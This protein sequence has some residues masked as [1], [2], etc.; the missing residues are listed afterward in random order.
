MRI[1][2]T[3]RHVEPSQAL[4]EYAEEK[5]GKLEKIV[6]RSFDANVIL[7][8][9]KYRN[10]AEVLLSAKGISVKAMEE[11]DDLYSAIDLVIDKVEKQVKKHR[12]KRK[13]HSNYGNPDRAVSRETEADA[14]PLSVDN[15][16]V[17]LDCFL[18]K[19]MSLDDAVKLLGD[20]KHDIL[21]FMN[22]ETK[23]YNVVC[24]LSDGRVGVVEP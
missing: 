1:S 17:H 24:K 8:V 3:F 7:S 6:N 19:P 20:S 23:Q 14:L 11:T 10:I 9:E 16:I 12:E 2:V 18:P 4:R 15:D 22:F 21:M 13:E 5:V